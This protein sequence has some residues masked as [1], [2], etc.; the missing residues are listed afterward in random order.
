ME[1]WDVCDLSLSHTEIS[2]GGGL[3]FILFLS[4]H[5]NLG[6]SET[7]LLMHVNN[8]FCAPTTN[9]LLA[10]CGGGLADE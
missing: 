5:Q 1:V 7:A 3:P 2:S 9:N 4:A 8:L 6:T 10:R